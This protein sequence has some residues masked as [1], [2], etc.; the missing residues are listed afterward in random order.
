MMN[1]YTFKSVNEKD[2]IQ[3]YEWA[4]EGQPKAILQ[5]VHGMAE[6]ATRYADFAE[7][8]AKNGILVAAHDHIGH[9]RS[10]VP[11][12]W[13]YFGA[14]EGWITMIYDVEEHRKLIDSKYPGIPHFVLGH[15]MGSFVT[16]IYL[17]EFGRDISGAII[18]GTAAKN[19]AARM[20]ASMVQMIRKVKGDKY[21]SPMITSLVF[22]GYLDRI[23]DHKSAYDWLTRDEEVVRKYDE[24]PACGFTFTAAGYA[25]LFSLLRYMDSNACYEKTVTS[26]PVFVVGGEED[27]VGAYGA[28]PKSYYEK[29]RSL[30]CEKAS[31]KIYPGMR[32]EILNEI[33]KEEVYEDMKNFILENI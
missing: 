20:G 21:L 10:S 14:K 33:G 8:L 32:N 31:L 22:G 7:Y 24:D 17:S 9:G 11:E 27:P 3:C 26:I 30:G 25:D 28:G 6:H 19:A 29:L 23:P 2:T 15:S 5:I 12:N 1:E 18:M 13:G 4:P 16:R